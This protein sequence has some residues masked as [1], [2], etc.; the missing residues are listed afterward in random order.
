MKNFKF[1]ILLFSMCYFVSG[2]SVYDTYNSSLEKNNNLKLK[3]EPKVVMRSADEFANSKDVFETDNYIYDAYLSNLY[4]VDKVTQESIQISDDAVNIA[5]VT[6]DAVYYYTDAVLYKISDNSKSPQKLYSLETDT[7]S[8]VYIQDKNIYI[9]SPSGTVSKSVNSAKKYSDSK[10]V[11]YQS[12]GNYELSASRLYKDNVYLKLTD[13][14]NPKNKKLIEV[15]LKNGTSTVISDNIDV[16]YFYN[17]NIIFSDFSGKVFCRNKSKNENIEYS[18]LATQYESKST[19]VVGE[20]IY[21]KISGKQVVMSIKDNALV[22]NTLK[23]QLLFGTIKTDNGFAYSDGVRL[24]LLDKDGNKTGTV[25][26]N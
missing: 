26:T 14:D 15:S 5:A 6:K 3:S 8:H 23:E 4:R 11:I 19:M 7:S 2:C 16:F 13:A 1:A 10:E 17:D 9:I 18:E 25:V 22:E 24:Y 12:V 20:Y 21:K